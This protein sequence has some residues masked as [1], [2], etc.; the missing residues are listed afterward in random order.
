MSASNV[1]VDTMTI[2][3]P[4]LG[5]YHLLERLAADEIA[6]IYK[7]KTIGIAGF[8]KVQVLKRVLPGSAQNPRFI[9]AF[10]DE[11]KIAFS[12]NHRNIV[13]VFE[14]GKVDGDLFLAMEYIPGANLHEL[15]LAARRQRN[16]CPVGLSCYLLG[17][18]AAGLEYAHRKTD[19]FGQDLDIIHCD[20]RPRNIACS[21]E[22]SVKILD[23]GISRAVWNMVSNQNMM[24][25]MGW[26]LRYL[27]PEQ[28]HGLP[29]TTRSDL[30]S[31]GI[32]LWE[33]LTG[34]ALFDGQSAQEIRTSILQKPIQPPATINP[35]VP[36]HLDNLT[37]LCLVRDPTSRI[38][39]AS[40]LQMEL[41]RIQRML[42]AVIG[43]RALS[44]Y[45]EELLPGYIDTRDVRQEGPE[46]RAAAPHIIF[47]EPLRSD[48]L[49]EAATELAQPPNPPAEV[50]ID[51]RDVQPISFDSP[52]DRMASQEAKMAGVLRSGWYLDDDVAVPRRLRSQKPSAISSI[53]SDEVTA[54]PT[55]YAPRDIDDPTVN[56]DLSPGS[57]FLGPDEGALDDP[58]T[59]GEED[60]DIVDERDISLSRPG[61]STSDT[62]PDDADIETDSRQPFAAVK[63]ASVGVGLGGDASYR[64]APPGLITS[65][66]GVDLERG[67]T[68]LLGE[69]KRFIACVVRLEGSEPALLEA[70]DLVTNIAFKL[71]GIVHDGQHDQ[72]TTLFGLPTADENDI[73]AA[74]RF[75]L[76]LNEALTGLAAGGLSVLSRVG[77]RAGTARMGGLP[78]QEGYQL[79]GNTL[80]ETES[81]AQHA[82]VGQT[83]LA[84]VA[85]RLASMHYSL[86][87][88]RPLRRHGKMIRCYRVAAPHGR[89][90]PHTDAQGPF[91]ARE[92]ELKAIRSAYREAVLR[93]TQRSI[94]VAGEPGIG[95]SRLADEFIARQSSEAQIIAAVATPHRLGTPYAMM[96][97]LIRAAIELY[98]GGRARS[99]MLD[100]LHQMLADE[101]E[102][103]VDLLTTLIVPRQHA[104]SE[105]GFSVLGI[106]R[107][108][109]RLL[110]RIIARGTGEPPPRPLIV[111]L[112]DLHWAD[113]A[114]VDC[115]SHLVQY[116]EE[117]VG[118]CLFLMTIR[119]DEDLVPE[120]LFSSGSSFL[121]LDE[122]DDH[123]RTRLIQEELGAQA[124]TE[125]I[126]E[127]ERRAGGNPFYIRELSRALHELRASG[128]GPTDVPPTVQG[129]VLGRVDRLPT[130]VKSL[131]QHAAVIG[132][133]FREGILA[134]LLNR[135]PARSLGILRNHGIIVPGL[136]TVA[137]TTVTSGKSEQFEREWVFRHVLIQEVV[138]ESISGVARRDLH[139]QVGE[140]MAS[141]VRRGSN[142]PPAEVARH[143][144]LGGLLTEAGEFYL[145]AANEAAAAFASREALLLYDRALALGPPDPV[146]EYAIHAG[147]E[148]MHAQ[149]G[150][151]VEQAADLEALRRLC[152]DDPTRLADLRNREALRLLRLGEFYRA[153][154]AAE[155]A[156]AA[157]CEALN[158][159]ARG[160]ALR[161]RAEAYERLGDHGRAIDA[162]TKALT[163]FEQEGSFP[164][165]V[166]ARIALGRIN[167]VQARYDEAFAQFDPALALIKETEDRW[168]ER[169]LRYNLAVVNYCRGDFDMA[170][171]EAHS[172]L[173]LCEQ[174]GDRGREA[175]N[176]SVL[177]IICLELGQ[178]GLARRHLEAAL[179]MHKE[180]GAQWSEAD[181]LV[182]IGLL[183]AA[184][185][186]YQ[187]ALRLLDRGK[188]IAERIGARYITINARNAIAW[189]LCERGSTDDAAHATDEA[190]EAAETA[191][192]ARLIVG[193]IP[194][195]SRS[196]RAT[197]MLGDLDAARALSRRAVELLEEQRIIE[198]PEEEIYYT[199]YRILRTLDDPT[200]AA[201]L[202]RAY[203]GYRS[204]LGR[205]Q[206][207]EHQ[208]SY[209]EHVPL[210]RAIR[211]DHG[212][213][214]GEPTTQG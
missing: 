122:L 120:N 84:G 39:S 21:F 123:D 95:K 74:I 130:P 184:S 174:F 109:R 3:Q 150:R 79:L 98:A 125:L 70:R 100:T 43:S 162:A 14:F 114:S 97:D 31:F 12:L 107:A 202:N 133:T 20:I 208:E 138:H 38:S 82:Q 51:S 11:A 210:N 76:D 78:S 182:Y 28:I 180:T 15:M 55:M 211:R 128:P 106:H 166:R 192:Q 110:D 34:V 17:E 127:V 7:V 187:R 16:L 155:Q 46:E 115:L 112:E 49:V 175:D 172:S 44:A 48:D 147:R 179:A 68:Q 126:R 189:T 183:E 146:R 62:D 45:I 8:E 71:E 9:R 42:G 85:A 105:A 54:G 214:L 204:K 129:V 92:V 37:M 134:Q 23:F 135:N 143:L 89:T 137:P 194:G 168:H 177:G 124:T 206:H 6:E 5:K 83:C 141:R 29:L 47:A 205:L 212:E 103:L 4:T 56:P 96:A 197:A 57:L 190:T 72:I 94:L 41:H 196:A 113:H 60:F 24:D 30:F 121:M 58:T 163:V 160:E 193:E 131:L 61:V 188:R 102:Q 63:S 22:G 200:A 167:L 209:S 33:L 67:Q 93:G 178:N 140:L 149:L 157:A 101:D 170:L 90:A 50:M 91:V 75:A 13:Q 32:I 118:P 40:E 117:S 203:D 77:I 87:A 65:P 164:G 73:A 213:L 136:R 148:Q 185:A 69:K 1:A 36:A 151:H 165:Q 52:I 26:D 99:R 186:R 88:M 66:S 144:E 104:T 27:S 25:M 116:P 64:D 10:I 201:Y 171:D 158:E 53:S 152:G 199:H 153:L 195:L 59:T 173:K 108:M 19:H 169:V 81:L 142:D 156:E 80:V 119:P 191:R 139:R 111:L 18:V 2:N 159:H 86:R 35:D 132:P 154:S 198:S 161:L 176:A 145:R 181:T 207:A